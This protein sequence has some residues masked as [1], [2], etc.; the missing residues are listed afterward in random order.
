MTGFQGASECGCSFR[1]DTDDLH[2]SLIPRRDS[3]NESAA[4][5]GDEHRVEIGILR[6]EL[7]AECPL[8][9]ER[10]V[11]IEGMHLTRTGL[12]REYLALRQRVGIPVTPDDERRAVAPDALDLRGRRDARNEDRGRHAASHRGIC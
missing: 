3:A 11:L 5:D 1:L 2:A 4:S 7:A 10:L 8:T 9:E 6:L 12:R